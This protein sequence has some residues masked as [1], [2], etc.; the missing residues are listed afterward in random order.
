MT[1]QAYRLL[2]VETSKETNLW[3]VHSC[4]V[5]SDDFLKQEDR[6]AEVVATPWDMVIRGRSTPGT[7]SS[8]RGNACRTIWQDD[9]IPLVV[10]NSSLVNSPDWLDE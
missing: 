7:A 10:A 4:V 5:V 9:R 1:P 6:I 8:Q 2:Q 3:T